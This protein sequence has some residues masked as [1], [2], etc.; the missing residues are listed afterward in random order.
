MCRRKKKE[1]KK[2]KSNT[3][4]LSEL[5][6][7]G[8]FTVVLATQVAMCGM[9]RQHGDVGLLLDAGSHL[10]QLGVGVQVAVGQQQYALP[11]SHGVVACWQALVGQLVIEVFLHLAFKVLLVPLALAERVKTD[12]VWQKR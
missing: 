1:G 8:P 4:Y 2:E 3:T 5:L 7:I 12:A 6:F 9:R 11:R 10:Q